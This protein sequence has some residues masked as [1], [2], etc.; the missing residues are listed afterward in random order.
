MTDGETTRIDVALDETER[1]FLKRGIP[2]FIAEYRATEDVFTR[3]LPYFLIVFLAE[4]TLASRLDWVWWQNVA[5]F[6][7]GLVLALAAWAGVNRFRRRPTWQRPDSV[8]PVEVVFFVLGP[9]F[10]R[11]AMTGLFGVAALLLTI[12][13]VFLGIVY[14][15]TSYG[16]TP[17]VGWAAGFTFR[18]VG[19][20]VGLFGRSMPLLLL[21]S[22][23]LFINAEVWQVAASLDDWLLW[24]VL[25]FFVAIG[26]VFLMVR[27]PAELR[28]LRSEADTADPVERCENSPLRDVAHDLG[29]LPPADPLSRRQEGNVLLVLFVSQ[30][31]QVLLV[32]AAITAFFLGFGLI[33]IRPDVIDAWLGDA[34]TT[35]TIATWNIGGVQFVATRALLHV[36]GF[37][38]TLSGFYFTVYVI[39]DSTYREEFFTEIVEEVRE[40]LAVRRVYLALRAIR[41][42]ETTV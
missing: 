7:A 14:L 37:L 1:W 12:N 29:D 38:G 23:T 8:G 34:V 11:W 2:H 25:G 10:V 5:A 26:V 17:M 41:R 32:T 13:L 31:V 15:A 24:L 30:A 40:S 21:F 6:V 33:A 19:A 27:L 35:S 20:V 36:A 9:A 16:V 22:I 18:Q 42:A 4:L 39:T 3:M 28:S